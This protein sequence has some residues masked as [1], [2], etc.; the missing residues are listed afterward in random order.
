MK[1][2]NLI[3]FFTFNNVLKDFAETITLRVRNKR[4]KGFLVST[5]FYNAVIA[6]EIYSIF[7][8]MSQKRNNDDYSTEE[9][10]S[11]KNKMHFHKN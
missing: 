10:F 3:F 5:I 2:C 9:K 6:A 11:F 4:I 1:P 7:T 8:E